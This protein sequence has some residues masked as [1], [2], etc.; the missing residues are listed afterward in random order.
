M[1]RQE[2]H[3]CWTLRGQYLLCFYAAGAPPQSGPTAALALAFLITKVGLAAQTTRTVA[4]QALSPK[5]CTGAHALKACHSPSRPA[6]AV[7]A[8][9]DP[10]SPPQA[11]EQSPGWLMSIVGG[12]ELVECAEGAT[13]SGK[14]QDSS[15]NL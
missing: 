8:F 10:G 2:R 4:Q 14:V 12:Q 5:H 9:H 6:P 13:F 7:C 3:P 1:A 11:F 15:K